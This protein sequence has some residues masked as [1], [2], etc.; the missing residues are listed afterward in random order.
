MMLISAVRD[1]AR[2][3]RADGDSGFMLIYVLVIGTLMTIMVAS[4]LMVSSSAILPSVRSAYSQAADAAAQGG[5]QAFIAYVDANC[6]GANSSVATC[7]LG[8]ND[9]TVVNI[10]LDGTA[11]AAYSATY[12][13]RAEK[14]PSNR[15]FRVASTG[16]VTLGG[17]TST[18]TVV[19]DVVGGSSLNILNYGIVT[20]FES[21]S[22]STVLSDWPRRT[23]AFDQSAIDAATVPIKGGQIVWSG[24]SPGTAAGKVAVCN[25]TFDA[26]GGR[27]TN[28]PKNAPNP[29]VDWTENGL[30]GNNYTNYQPCQTSWGTLT[31]V[32]AP[33][34]PANGPGGYYSND[35]LLLSNS[36]PG[37]TGPLFNQPVSTNWSYTTADAGICGTASGQNYRSFFLQCAGYPV[38][39]G[40][41][42][43]PTSLYRNVQSGQ[44][45]QIPAG[46]PVLPA[47]TTCLYSGPTR[48]VFS[49]DTATVTSPQTTSTFAVTSGSPAQCYAGATGAGMA[50]ATVNFAS[51]IAI[52][53]IEANTDG[54]A[55]NTTPAIAH[56][57]SGWP[58]TGQVLGNVASTSNSVFYMTNGSTGTTTSS[59]YTATATDAGYTPAVGDIPSTKPDG[60]WTPQWPSYSNGGCPVTSAIDLKFVNCNVTYSPYPNAYNWI[61]AGVNAALAANP[62]NYTTAAALQT[63]INSYV[64]QGNSADAANS[65]PTNSNSTSHR[66]QVSVA[67]GN[68]GGCTQ[69]TGVAGTPTDTPVPAPSTDPFFA[70]TNGTSHAAP[71]TDTTCF[72]ATVTEQIGQTVLGLVKSWGDGGLLGLGLVAGSTIP[73]FKV[74]VTVKNTTT[75][76]T[77]T[78]AT[79]TFP[80]MSDVTQ[81]QMGQSGTFGASGPGDLYV[82]G[83]A[84]HTM[85][86]IAQNDVTVTNN[87]GT[88][89]PT[90]SALE[91][92]AQNSVRVY[93]PVSCRITD[94]T[95]ISETSPGFCPDDLTG[96]YTGVAATGFRPDQQY[97][98]MRGDLA[99]LTIHG[100]VFALGNA[101]AHITC[102]QPPDGGGLCGGEFTTDNYGRGA[103]LGYVTEIGTIAMG[104]HAPVGQEWDISDTSGQ[105]SRPY[106]GYELAQQYQNLQVIFAAT[107]DVAG[108]LNTDTVTSSHWH[109]VSVSSS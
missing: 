84:G 45:P 29:Y 32:L 40:G 11:S 64:S 103:P 20:G 25:A 54:T 12:D 4:T 6:G 10:P 24:A 96:L 77:S 59:A 71:S 60:A 41:S 62:S 88:T 48:I 95:L 97:V 42:P 89:D 17:L 5:L 70:N 38:E 9:S 100:A 51:P 22:S 34:N 93:H 52:H 14:D 37:G 18:K 109:I 50:G 94:P 35:A 69:S 101:P 99:G 92:V 90:T 80:S 36:Y 81:Y 8:T 39:V 85:A 21:Q 79:S 105:S 31:K 66:W 28:L 30:A 2:R 65:T 33:A 75:T 107:P 73:Q 68:G 16:T 43:A 49:G 15:Y 19:G 98:N 104:H 78:Q 55:P 47:N 61:K 7:T 23:I 27:S 13:W 87:L 76:T 108:V 56:G 67:Q 57:S 82:E 91:V 63:L 74:T 72:T 26:K 46:T 102:P 1:R 58:V 3:A 106:S 86:V 83:N 44:G 53:A